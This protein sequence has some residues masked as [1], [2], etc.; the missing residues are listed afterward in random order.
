MPNI[1]HF[2]RHHL[3]LQLYA[4]YL[5]VSYRNNHLAIVEILGSRRRLLEPHQRQKCASKFITLVLVKQ[6][7][8]LLHRGFQVE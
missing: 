5:R 6:R 7:S 2:S 8:R 4:P 1:S 3:F